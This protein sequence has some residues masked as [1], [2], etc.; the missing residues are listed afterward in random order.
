MPLPLQPTDAFDQSLKSLK[1]R[2][3]ARGK[4][5]IDTMEQIEFC[6]AHENATTTIPLGRRAGYPEKILWQDI[7]REIE[8][9]WIR[10]RMD[11]MVKKPLSSPM[12]RHYFSDATKD[13]DEDP[14]WAAVY[15]R[16]TASDRMTA[17]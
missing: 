17:G 3:R 6:L 9:P 13:E 11:L 1:A 4:D 12:F 15:T 2:I 14:E 5:S 10:K 8:R 16:S 7:W